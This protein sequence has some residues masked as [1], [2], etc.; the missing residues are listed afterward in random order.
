MAER[1][2]LAEKTVENYVSRILMKLWLARR[3]QAAVMAS[4]LI[5]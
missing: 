4:K 3:T 2:S 1:L 5:R